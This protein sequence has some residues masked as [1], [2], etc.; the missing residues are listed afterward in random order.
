[1]TFEG[2]AISEIN[3]VFSGYET[4]E[5]TRTGSRSVLGNMN[6]LMDLY[7]HAILYESGLKHCD[8]TDIIRQI[9]R[10]PQR[11]L[12]WAKSID[13]ARQLISTSKQD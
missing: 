7:I 5:F 10:T 11:N 13:V 1:M 4:L 8:L 3:R 2:F 9:N 6:D 12:G